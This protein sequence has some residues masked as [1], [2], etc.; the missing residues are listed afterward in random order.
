MRRRTLLATV[1]AVTLPVAG[2]LSEGSDGDGPDTSGPTDTPD[3]GGSNADDDPRYEECSRG[4]IPYGQFPPELRDGIDAALEGGHTAD[5]IH[6]GD[7]T[8]VDRG[9]TYCDPSI[10]ADSDRETLRLRV[11]EPKSL[12]RP[13]PVT[14]ENGRDGDRTVTVEVTAADGDELLAET[15]TLQGG[16]DADFGRLTRVGVHDLHVGVDGGESVE[17][18]TVGITEPRFD[19]LVV[20]GSGE[21]HV[22]GTVAESVP[23]RFES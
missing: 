14:V 8:D 19:V 5:R 2:C 7:A 11:I 1:A 13:R 10:G 20:V 17:T 9:D 18:G 23:C 22:T 16:D 3:A 15:R 6:L 4:V 12:P 21:L